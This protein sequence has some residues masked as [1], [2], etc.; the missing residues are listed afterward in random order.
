M[1][2]D[3]RVPGAQ[4]GG[5]V[6]RTGLALVHEGEYVVPAA[7]AEDDIERVTGADGTTTINY[8][9]PVEVQVVGALTEQDRL[10][11][12][13]RIWERLADALDRLE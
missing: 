8:F 7:G 5:R 10:A 6:R 3:G 11:I 13:E 12:E 1:T 2:E 4:G 9:F